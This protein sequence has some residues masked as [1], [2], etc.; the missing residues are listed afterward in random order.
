MPFLR[1]SRACFTKQPTDSTDPIPHQAEGPVQTVDVAPAGKQG[2][3][4]FP[5]GSFKSVHDCLYEAITELDI[6]GL[7]EDK[8]KVR[9]K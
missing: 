9:A 3:N 6:A 7:Q 2:V 8:M 5:T 4:F 1:G